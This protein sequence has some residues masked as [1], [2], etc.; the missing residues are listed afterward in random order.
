MFAFAAV[1]FVAAA[2]GQAE[3][4][5]LDVK[6]LTPVA[7]YR[8][9]EHEPVDIV[10]DGQPRAKIYVADPDPSKNLKILLEEMVEVIKL[11]TGAKLEMVDAMPPANQ[12]AIVIG[13]CAAS[14]KAGIN[15]AE[16]PIE[17][18]VVKTQPNRVYLVGTTQEV[19]EVKNMSSPYSNDGTAWAV[20]DFLERFAGVRWYWP[21]EAGGRS[22]VEAK[23]LVVRPAHYVDQPAFRKREFFPYRY[24]RPW[25]SYWR[26]RSGPGPTARAIPE[27]VE[28]LDLVPLFATLRVGN[29]WPY[30]IKVHQPQNFR[31]DPKRWEQHKAMFQKNKDGSPNYRMLC[32]SSQETLDYLLAG[33]ERFWNEGKIGGSPWVTTT[34]VTVSP[35]DYRVD[36]YCEPCRKLHNPGSVYS[37]ASKVM[38]VFVKKLAEEVERRWPDKKVLYLP[39]WNYT[40]CPEEIDF[41][42]NLEIQMCTMA[43]G[44]MRQPGPRKLMENS[45]RAWSKKVGGRI[46][47][48]EYSHRVADWTN[49]LLQYPHLVQDYYRANR[50]VLVGSFLNGGGIS[51]WSQTAPTLY[52]WM[53]VLWN[54]DVDIDAILDAYCKR[55]FGKAARTTRELMQLMCDRWQKTRWSRSLGDSGKITTPIFNDNWPPEIVEKMTELWKKTRDELKD[56]PVSLQRF[57]YITWTFEAFLKEAE[58]HWAKADGDR[59]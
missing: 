8:A 38:G 48:W 49:A 50:D 33:C 46:Q 28:Y 37:A 43:F 19:P 40:V 9:P 52:C 6:D 54:P 59:K 42:D 14:R 51:E 18:F 31:G 15:A 5:Y 20:A 17:G 44:L 58:G 3:A 57:E 45:M 30:M 34:C 53:K 56:D 32:Y 39:Y 11:S 7:V 23:T 2:T 4:D 36:C 25:W 21:T 22:I 35:G 55:M 41:P 47:T 16:I 1:L 13:D 29:S 10:A 26:E 24:T 27:E 12:P